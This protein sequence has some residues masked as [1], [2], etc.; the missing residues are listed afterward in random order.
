MTELAGPAFPHPLDRLGKA[1]NCRL[2]N[3][4][5]CCQATIGDSWIP[6]SKQ[7]AN[8][9]FDRIGDGPANDDEPGGFRQIASARR[10]PIEHHRHH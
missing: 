1:M 3:G 5:I 6:L 10:R 7:E 4:A 9:L 2:I 8:N